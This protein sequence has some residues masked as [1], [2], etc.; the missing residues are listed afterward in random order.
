[1]I[2]AQYWWCIV[3]KEFPIKFYDSEM[4]EYDDLE[5]LYCLMSKEMCELS[6][7]HSDEPDSYR[8]IPVRV[9]YEI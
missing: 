9:S 7:K 3:N 5:F 8:I 6:I 1:M 4:D 2:I